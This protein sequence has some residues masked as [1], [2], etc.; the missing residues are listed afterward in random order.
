VV[1]GTAAAGLFVS[2]VTLVGDTFEGVQRNAVLGVNTAVLSAAAAVYPVVGG[3]LAGVAWNAPFFAYLLAL[4]VAGVAWRVLPTE[5]GIPQ[6]PGY[7]A[8]M[9][10]V[11]TSTGALGFYAAT[12]LTEL[13]LFGAIFTALP[14]LLVDDYASS[15]V[16]VGLVITAAEVVSTAAAAL[17]GRLA[18]RA[19]NATLVRAGIAVYAVGLLVVPFAV[20]PVGVAAG[21]S[22]AGGGVGLV[23][24]SVDAGLTDHVPADLRAGALSL[25]NSVTFL[26]RAS[27]PVAFAALAGS[28]GYDS[29]FTLAGVVSLAVVAVVTAAARWWG[30]PSRRTV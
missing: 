21:A 22:I 2:T 23:L 28:V 12:L 13:L 27:G 9:A 15:A 24:P 7:L 3:L 19:S 29:L 18:H 6:R 10:R 1:Q 8:A 30:R 16:V 20:S 17:N 5:V 4:P 11:A 26:G 14:F 25:R